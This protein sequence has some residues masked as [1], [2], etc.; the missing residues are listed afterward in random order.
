MGIP[1]EERDKGTEALMTDNFLKLMSDNKLQLQ[2]AQKRP[3]RINVRKQTNK[4][5]RHIISKH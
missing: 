3:N 2:E 1:E 5:P 4:T